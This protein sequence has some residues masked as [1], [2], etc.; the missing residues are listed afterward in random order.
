MKHCGKRSAAPVKRMFESLQKY[1]GAGR[2][3]A[4]HT[5]PFC[6][7][8]SAAHRLGGQNLAA[9]CTAAGENLTAVGRSHSLAEAMNLGTMTTAGLIGTLHAVHLLCVFTSM[10]DSQFW[11]QQS[12]LS[13]HTRSFCSIITEKY[14][15]VNLFFTFFQGSFHFYSTEAVNCSLSST[16]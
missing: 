12:I 16:S 2:N 1:N 4:P 8:S 6:C 10:L 5:N 9:L 13:D 7:C 3:I 15:Q 11:L 14:K